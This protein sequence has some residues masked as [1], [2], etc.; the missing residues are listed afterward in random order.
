MTLSKRAF[1]RRILHVDLRPVLSRPG[2]TPS[3]IISLTAESLPAGVEL[4]AIT[5]ISLEGTTVSFLAD[6]G[7]AGQYYRLVVRF[8]VAS[9]PGQMIEGISALQVDRV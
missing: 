8:E 5:D 4:P 7:V 3:R 9:Q 2:D 6:G 1:D